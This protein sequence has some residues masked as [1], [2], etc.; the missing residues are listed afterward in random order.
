MVFIGY[1]G[2]VKNFRIKIGSN[3]ID[4]WQKDEIKDFPKELANRLLKN[5]NFYI[6][7]KNAKKEFKEEKKIESKEDEI[8]K[9]VEEEKNNLFDLDGDGNIDSN[10][11]RIAAKTLAYARKN[12]S[13]EE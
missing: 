8:I 7:N 2:D 1:K 13:K 4:N 6:A 9:E 5:S 3:I 12:K 10:D 11:Y